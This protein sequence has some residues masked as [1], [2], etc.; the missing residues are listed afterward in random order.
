MLPIEHSENKI[1]TQSGL[2]GNE[3]GSGVLHSIVQ[4][5]LA[6]HEYR[7]HK[8]TAMDYVSILCMLSEIFASYIFV[9]HWTGVLQ[10]QSR[11]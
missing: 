11:F 8:P 4:Q 3:T 10:V 2:F 6:L 5:T 9:E 7:R 1:I